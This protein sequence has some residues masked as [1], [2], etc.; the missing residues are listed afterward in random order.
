MTVHTKSGK[1]DTREKR[2]EGDRMILK[3]GI[4]I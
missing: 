3:L 4:H 2:Q 1:R